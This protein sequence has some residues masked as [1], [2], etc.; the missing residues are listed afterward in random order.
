[1]IGVVEESKYDLMCIYVIYLDR[2]AGFVH[3]V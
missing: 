2:I 1:V 3:A